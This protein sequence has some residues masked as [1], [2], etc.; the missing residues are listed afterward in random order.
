MQRNWSISPPSIVLQPSALVPPPS[1]QRP[2]RFSLPPQLSPLNFSLS[3]SLSLS[4]S[5]SLS[6][7]PYF[8]ALAAL[9]ASAPLSERAPRRKA[10][11]RGRKM[12]RKIRL[13]TRACR[14][15]LD[16]SRVSRTTDEH[17]GRCAPQLRAIFRSLIF[18]A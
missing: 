7:A 17:L 5:I 18:E 10:I 6:I 9:R 13:L 1:S 4:L 15:N 14:Q 2:C 12:A 3:L 8:L 16:I 11:L